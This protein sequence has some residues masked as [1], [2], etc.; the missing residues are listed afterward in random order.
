MSGKNKRAN[1]SY[2]LL[3]RLPCL[4][5]ES[6]PPFSSIHSILATSCP[7]LFLSVSLILLS[8]LYLSISSLLSTFSSAQQLFTSHLHLSSLHQPILVDVSDCHSI[9]IRCFSEQSLGKNSPRYDNNNDKKKNTMLVG[10]KKKRDPVLLRFVLARICYYFLSSLSFTQ[11]LFCRSII[12]V[13]HAVI[14]S[15]RRKM[16][17]IEACLFRSGLNTKHI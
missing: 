1:K 16:S 7:A 9:G 17:S 5:I 3:D 8:S 13:V 10:F 6:F 2:V 12:E 14:N 4:P 11:P 15:T